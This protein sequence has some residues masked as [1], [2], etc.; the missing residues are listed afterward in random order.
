[1]VFSS[2]KQGRWKLERRDEMKRKY[3]KAPS[4]VL[5]LVT[6]HEFL[7]SQVAVDAGGACL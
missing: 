5:A 1:M 4:V 2:R 3:K 7:Y 6:G